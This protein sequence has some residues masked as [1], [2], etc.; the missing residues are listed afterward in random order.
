MNFLI[1]RWYLLIPVLLLASPLVIILYFMMIYGYAFDESVE[2]FKAVGKADTKFRQGTYTEA[3]F[4]EVQ[5]GFSG[6]DIFD[7]LGIPLERHD[8]DTKWCYS[9]PVGGAE[10]YHERTFVMEGGKVKSVICR[11]H[12]PATKD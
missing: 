8:G 3:K 6:K 11:F 5:P 9:V 2:C 7:R 1:K 12:T 10:Y 4:H